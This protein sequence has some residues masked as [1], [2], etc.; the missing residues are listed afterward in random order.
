MADQPQT[1]DQDEQTVKELQEKARKLQESR[2]E[3]REIKTDEKLRNVKIYSPYR[4]YFDG[5]A[6]S[7]SG[8]NTTGSFDILPRHKNFMTLLVPSK[9]TVR[10]KSGDSDFQIERGIMHVRDNQVTVFLDV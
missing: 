9:M 2:G 1:Q 5:P 3:L 6:D 8:L 4:V 10:T 7:V